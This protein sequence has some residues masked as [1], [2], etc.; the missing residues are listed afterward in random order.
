MS[1]K[2][3]EKVNN[4]VSEGF[5]RGNKVLKLEAE[6]KRLRKDAFAELNAINDVLDK[7]E[8]G[9][10][11]DYNVLLRRIVWIEKALKAKAN[12]KELPSKSQL[13]ADVKKETKKVISPLERWL[14]KVLNKKNK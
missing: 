3:E 1:V 5:H 4:L 13:K 9:L 10:D 14:K 2:L 8:D 6:I 12:K 7:L 11:V